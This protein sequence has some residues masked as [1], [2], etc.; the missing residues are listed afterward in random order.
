MK[1][2]P[3]NLAELDYAKSP[4]GLI[5]AV[6]Q[7]VRDD[8]VLMLGYVDA[9]SLA[10][11]FSSER[12]TFHSRSKGRLW[13]K[14]E[15]SGHYLHFVEGY[16]D[17]DRD[18]VLL[19]AQPEG[20]TCHTGAASCFEESG[21]P[22]GEEPEPDTD[23]AAPTGEAGDAPTDL[24]F[25]R[26]LEDLLHA[27]MPHAESESYTS[28]LLAKGTL[29]VAQKV[30]EEGVE[31]ALEAAGGTDERLLEEAADLMYHYLLLLRA[32]GYRLADVVT[33]LRAREG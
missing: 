31:M 9:E 4:D 5:P 23:D 10:A 26:K 1:L 32:K 11:T 17:C 29:K 14:G 7:H 18:A 28:R 25:L 27:R 20:P 2:T 16:A 12:V 6:V 21:G 33:V 13:T 8:R 30:G 22:A 24:G 19:L 3:A 15:S